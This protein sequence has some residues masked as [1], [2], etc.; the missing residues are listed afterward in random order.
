M[1][2][3][4]EVEKLVETGYSD[5]KNDFFDFLNGNDDDKEKKK[6]F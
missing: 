6:G 3:D 5:R 1:G 4:E 2:Y